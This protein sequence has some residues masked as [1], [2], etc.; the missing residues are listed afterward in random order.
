MKTLFRLLLITTIIYFL[1]ILTFIRACHSHNFG[2]EH[3]KSMEKNDPQVVVNPNNSNK[4]G[5]SNESNNNP[6]SALV[7]GG[8]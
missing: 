3:L 2:H 7:N 5:S 1:S 4:N 8:E 6:L